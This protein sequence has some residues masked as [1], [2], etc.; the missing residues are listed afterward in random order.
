MPAYA[1]D[2]MHVNAEGLGFMS[3][4]RAG[5]VAETYGVPVAVGFGAVV[6]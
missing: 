2:V 6:L 4:A 3:T 1:W 5:A